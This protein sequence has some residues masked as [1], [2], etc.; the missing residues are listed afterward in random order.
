MPE[1]FDLVSAAA[2][3]WPRAARDLDRTRSRSEAHD[4]RHLEQATSEIAA[5]VH[6]D[7]KR[8]EK[9]YWARRETLLLQP[10][11]SPE[12]SVTASVRGAD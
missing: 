7:W 10:T 8:N 3:T 2:A 1:S 5:R 11:P 9:P 12:S 4:E 6:P